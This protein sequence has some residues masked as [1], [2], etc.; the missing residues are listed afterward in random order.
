MSYSIIIPSRN[1]DNLTAC[2]KAL[3]AA[4]ET[5]RVIVID[6]L[7]PVPSRSE[8][9][10]AGLDLSSDL[11][12]MGVDPFVYARNCNLG[13]MAAEDD[14]IVLLNDDALLDDGTF[15]DLASADQKWGVIAATT[16]VT[17]HAKQYRREFYRIR[18]RAV[19]V[20]AFVCVYIPRH[21]IDTVGLLDERFTSYGGEDIDYCLRVREAGLEVGVSDYCYVDHS[22][23][24]ST[25][26]PWREGNS[27][28][29]DIRE[30]NRIGR[31][32][33]GVKWPR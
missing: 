22:K 9:E 8:L 30:S 24:R 5:A 16:N 1:I 4:G 11:V 33:W 10:F 20:A 26:R 25:F 14:N 21:T 7:D 18:A 29:G 15:K 12:L 23:L 13:I 17:G 19:D 6:D 32:K 2:V 27:G 3:R 28:G 31:E